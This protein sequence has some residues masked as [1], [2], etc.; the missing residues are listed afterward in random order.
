MSVV[1]RLTSSGVSGAKGFLYVEVVA[2][3]CS[4][5]FVMVSLLKFMCCCL[6]AVVVGMISSNRAVVRSS[7]EFCDDDDAV[8]EE[9]EG[10]EK[11]KFF[12]I[13]D[14]EDVEEGKL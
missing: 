4:D 13:R 2:V 10:G 3:D 14:E 12:S 7:H 5:E 9:E 8:A 6:I 11:L 1:I